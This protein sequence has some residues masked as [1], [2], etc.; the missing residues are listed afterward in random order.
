MKQ[1]MT[2][3]IVAIIGLS[4][5]TTNAYAQ[6][7]IPNWV[8]NTA[9]WWGQGQISDSEFVKAMQYLIDHGI[10]VISQAPP[11]K[12]PTNDLLP[13]ATDIGPFWNTYSVKPHYIMNGFNTTTSSPVIIYGLSSEIQRQYTYQSGDKSAVSVYP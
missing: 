13:S 9:L 3:V 7:V 8:K 11:A 5:I 1:I 12:N 2:F 6:T 4:M 10:L